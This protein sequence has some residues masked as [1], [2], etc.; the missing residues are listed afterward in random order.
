MN[1]KRLALTLVAFLALVAA[2]CGGLTEKATEKATEKLA[3]QACQDGEDSENCDVDISEDGVQVNTDDGSFEVGEN[4]DYPTD[5]PEYLRVDGIAP[6]SAISIGDG[7]MSTTIQGVGV[8][9]TIRRQAEAAGC[10]SE[11][12]SATEI[13]NVAILKCDVGQVSVT[14]QDDG[15]GEQVVSVSVIPEA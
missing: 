15:T 6:L 13:A 5:Y 7:S 14:G 8:M 2:G 4:V 12:D 1:I 10:T 11:Q 9:D 3:E